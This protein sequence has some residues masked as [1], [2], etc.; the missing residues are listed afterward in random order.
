MLTFLAEG[1]SSLQKRPRCH[2]CSISP[3][4]L[5]YPFVYHQRDAK[6]MQLRAKLPPEGRWRAQMLWCSRCAVYLAAQLRSPRSPKAAGMPPSCSGWEA[7][8]R[9]GAFQLAWGSDA[10]RSQRV[11]C[12]PIS[13]LA[14]GQNCSL[15]KSTFSSCAEPPRGWGKVI[16]KQWSFCR[17]W[18]RDTR[19]RVRKGCAEEEE[20]EEREWTVQLAVKAESTARDKTL[21]GST[22][23]NCPYFYRGRVKELNEATYFGGQNYKIK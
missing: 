20:E 18:D 11:N 2:R 13:K 5:L 12:M 9:L 21:L 19:G 15:A 17:S 14:E 22:W 1:T 16:P 10:W 8:L 6:F 3:L 7:Q 23:R 4:A